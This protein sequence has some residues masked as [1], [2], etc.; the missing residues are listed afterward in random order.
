MNADSDTGPHQ[1][2]SACDL[3][4]STS[5]R[6]LYTASDR[7]C[8]DGPLWEIAEC[9]G[10]GV[11]RTLPELTDDELA[12]YYPDEYWGAPE[13][14]Q[15]WINSSQSEKTGFLYRCGLSGG[16][17]LDVGCGSGFFLRALDAEKWDRY[18][19]EPS[20]AAAKEA[21][22]FVGTGHVVA[23]TLTQSGFDDS[24]FDV[25]TLWS[26]LE[27]AN[28]PQ[29]YLRDAKRVLKAGGT[30]VIQLP[31]AAS[32][33]ARIF[34]GDWFALD[35]PRHRYHFNLPLLQKLLMDSG[36]EIYRATYFSKAHN[37]HALRQSLKTRLL[38]G[39]SS[40]RS[41]LFLMSIPFIKPF[42]AVMSALGKGATLTIAAHSR[43]W[44]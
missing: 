20:E 5:V 44:W 4:G 37:S 38:R 30:L 21:E 40:L 11:L 14:S 33:Q 32:Y 23:G 35:V 15:R 17:I 6:E 31:N 3:C 39:G 7:L 43:D 18:G 24:M 29:A 12:L 27:H 28:A 13:P 1:V 8:N 41:A 19:V 9:S 2:Q 16:R 34:K 26:S 42:D 10:C 36:F 25:I 22:R